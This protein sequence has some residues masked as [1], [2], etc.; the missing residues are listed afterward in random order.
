MR[1]AATDV[2]YAAERN[3]AERIG[4]DAERL[5]SVP[6]TNV[7]LPAKT[8]SVNKP[9]SVE[10]QSSKKGR[11]PGRP[12]PLYSSFN[13]EFH[14]RLINRSY[15]AFRTKPLKSLSTD[16]IVFRLREKTL[17]PFIGNKF[18]MTTTFLTRVPTCDTILPISSKYFFD[19]VMGGIF[20]ASIK[21]VHPS[22]ER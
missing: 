20:Q 12:I 15:R 10:A 22:H 14:N 8:V 3:G 13:S 21:L 1:A 16:E 17:T 5:R 6:D 4:P 19:N 9:A 2:L 11:L 18:I 7:L